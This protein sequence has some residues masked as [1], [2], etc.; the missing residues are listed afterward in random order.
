MVTHEIKSVEQ[1]DEL[2]ESGFLIKQLELTIP[3]PDRH[4]SETGINVGLGADIRELVRSTARSNAYYSKILL[5]LED[6]GDDVGPEI[7]VAIVLT[8]PAVRLA[9]RKL[10]EMLT[11]LEGETE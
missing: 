1:L 9:V 3:D 5:T 2:I 10:D 11:E 4:R 7:L 6:A 8:A